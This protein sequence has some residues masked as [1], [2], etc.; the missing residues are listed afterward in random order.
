VDETKKEATFFISLD[1]PS[2]SVVTMS[3]TTQDGT[4][5]AGSDFVAKNGYLSFATGQTAMMV[6]VSLLNDNIPENAEAFNLVLSS[7]TNATVPDPVG[8][9]IIA[10]NDA[11]R[12]TMS[13]IL[14]DDVVVDESQAFAEFLVRLDAPNTNTGTCPLSDGF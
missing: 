14:V 3:F 10:G 8:A 1:K 7:I 6:T 9:A 11:T 5:L 12:V 2:N 13:N 4:A